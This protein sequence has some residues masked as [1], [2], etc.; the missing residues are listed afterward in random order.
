MSKDDYEITAQSEQA[1]FTSQMKY[2]EQSEI[3]YGIQTS[4]PSKPL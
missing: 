2:C 3:N 4:V 1:G